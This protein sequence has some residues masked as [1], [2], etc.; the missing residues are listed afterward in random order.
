MI[1]VV[2]T[3]WSF[4]PMDGWVHGKCGKLQFGGNERHIR[5]MKNALSTSSVLTRFRSTIRS[6]M[7]AVMDILTELYSPWR[8]GNG[9]SEKAGNSKITC[10]IRHPKDR[11]VI[12]RSASWTAYT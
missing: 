2:L 9:R 6:T 5:G 3:S 11:L 8:S 10:R 1:G 4:L 12:H 7:N